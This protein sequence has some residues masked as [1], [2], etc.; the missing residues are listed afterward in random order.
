MTAVSG[1]L[2]LKNAMTV[3]GKCRHE[4]QSHP[5]ARLPWQLESKMGRNKLKGI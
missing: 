4:I 5:R 1:L 2:P 3:L